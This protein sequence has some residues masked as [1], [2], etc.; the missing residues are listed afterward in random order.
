MPPCTA[1]SRPK[2]LWSQ[3]NVIDPEQW[4]QYSEFTK[5]YCQGEAGGDGNKGAS[6]VSELHLLL[7]ENCMIRRLKSEILQALP[8]KSRRKFA[9]EMEDG[10]V[11]ARVLEDFREFL[12]RSGQAA[13]L[14]K[15]KS[16]IMEIALQR[17]SSPENGGGGGFKHDTARDEGLSN[18]ELSEKRKS[19]LMQL[20]KNTGSA[21]L[22][23]IRKHIASIMDSP[24]CPKFLVFAHHHNVLDSLETTVF[25]GKNIVRI[26]GSTPPKERQ[27]RINR[28]Q[29]DPTIKAALLGITAAGVAIT[30]TAASRVVFTELFWTPAALLQV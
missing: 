29:T 14:A 15:K 1:L 17:L 25:R 12:T 6:N 26:D 16:H 23:A 27:T 10:D 11:K 30:L 24:T 8:P 28:F 2:E 19:I 3:L 5:R 13:T 4:P 22:P 18:R 9:V 20:Y 7:R 21:K